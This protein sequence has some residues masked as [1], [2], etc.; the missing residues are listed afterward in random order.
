MLF[1][2]TLSKKETYKSDYLGE[3]IVDLLGKS[4]EIPN[5]YALDVIPVEPDYDARMDLVAYEVYGDDMYADLLGKLNGTGN[6]FEVVEGQKLILPG[7]DNLLD[8]NQEPSKLWSEQYIND[9][10]TRPRPKLK[11]EKRKPNEAVVGDKRFNIDIVSK[12]II[13]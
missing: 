5:K 12:I 2:T 11:T 4:F 10:E 1:S 9:V 3:E 7:L 6:P 8:F 13:Y